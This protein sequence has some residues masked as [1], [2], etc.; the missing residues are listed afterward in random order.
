M[1]KKYYMTFIILNC[2]L[3]VFIGCNIKRGFSLTQ[4]FFYPEGT[5]KSYIDWQYYGQIDFWDTRLEVKSRKVDLVVHDRKKKVVLKDVINITCKE[6][7]AYITWHDFERINIIFYD[8]PS[9][10]HDDFEKKKD[11]VK[12]LRE[13]VYV[14]NCEKGKFQRDF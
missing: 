4:S 9:M 1:R 11:S 7:N 12:I 5:G 14:F 8:G 2:F 3:Y 6:G 10:L 13:L